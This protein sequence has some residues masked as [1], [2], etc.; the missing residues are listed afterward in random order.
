MSTL[1]P[2]ING[3]KFFD[4]FAS[5]GGVM[6]GS[7]IH[8]ATTNTTTD[9][10]KQGLRQK[11]CMHKLFYVLPNS[12]TLKKFI[13]VKNLCQYTNLCVLELVHEEVNAC[14]SLLKLFIHIDQ[15]VI[16]YLTIQNALSVSHIS[17]YIVCLNY[18]SC[19]LIV[20]GRLKGIGN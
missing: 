12:K 6:N 8:I 18:L 1:G 7:N 4:M 16:K 3:N 17:L 2:Y 13:D 10:Q 14:A 19:Q 15:I 5:I 9:L 20:I 11:S